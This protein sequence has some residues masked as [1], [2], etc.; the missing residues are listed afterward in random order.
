[1]QEKKIISWTNISLDDLPTV[2]QEVRKQLDIPSLVILT[3]EVGAG[4]TTFTKEFV[5]RV[6]G[7]DT[8]LSPTYSLISETPTLM[9]ADFYRL[10]NPEE[11]VHLEFELY[12]EE[13]QFA[14]IEWGR[15]FLTYLENYLSDQ[16]SY[17][18][19]RIE[20]AADKRNLHLFAFS[21]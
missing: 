15:E 3:G 17:Y 18:E 4:K 10:Q 11:L 16:F 5:R 13:K 12:L 2:V 9:H 20:F 21:S 14:F 8:I 7:N 1:M 19:L 6:D